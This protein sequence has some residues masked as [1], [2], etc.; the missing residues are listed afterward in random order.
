MT[1][2]PGGGSDEV[3]LELRTS[4]GAPTQCTHNFAVEFVWKSTTFDRM[5]NAMKAFAVDENSVSMYIYHRL[6]GHDLEQQLLKGTL[7]KRFVCALGSLREGLCPPPTHPPP[8]VSFFR[9][10]APGLPELNHSQISAVKQVLQHPL[11]LIQASSHFGTTSTNLLPSHPPPPP[12]PKRAHSSMQGPPGTGKTVTTASIVYHLVRQNQGKVLVCAPSNIA[13]D[14]LTEKI[15]KT[16]VKVVRV[17]AKSREAIDSSVDF[18]ALHNQVLKLSTNAELQKLQKLKRD[19][20]ELRTSD[21]RRFRALVRA[22]ERELLA[23]ADVI[24]CTCVG[25]GDPRL[26]KMRFRSVIIDEATQA[27]EPECMVPI[28]LGA[29]QVVL[30]GDHCQLGPVVMCKSGE[31]GLNNFADPT[32]LCL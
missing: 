27:T 11:S 1:K 19:Q 21:E 22:A 25:A 6:L 14:Q 20:G 18:L 24:C 28:V 4:G 13:V 29:K 16:G 8:V 12:N 2:L 17:A 30:V 5:Q 31:W 7:P 10:V 26:A 3:C 32:A 23:A 9:F 15:N